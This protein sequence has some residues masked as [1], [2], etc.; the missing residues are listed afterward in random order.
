LRGWDPRP[1]EQTFER[2]S[3]V[4]E[5]GAVLAKDALNRINPA[6]EAKLVFI[7]NRYGNPHHWVT[8][9]TVDGKLYIVDFSAG[10][11]WKAMMGLLGPY[12]SLKGYA[13]FL[14][15]LKIPNFKLELVEY[16]NNK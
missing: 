11:N 1:P 12:E 6:Y 13:D 5:D 8:A 16:R 14:S 9:F 3:G 15:S 4:C 7:K 2:R 10:N